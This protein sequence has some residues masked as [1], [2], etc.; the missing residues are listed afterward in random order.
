M[1][2]LEFDGSK[3]FAENFELLLAVLDG[4]DAEMAKILRASTALLAKIVKDGER[5]PN[6]RAAFNAAIAKALDAV[7]ESGRETGGS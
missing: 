3:S 5:D 4:I 2:G 7:A 6:A 1:A